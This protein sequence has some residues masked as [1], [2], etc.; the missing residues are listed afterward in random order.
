VLAWV[1]QLGVFA[2]VAAILYWLIG[3]YRTRTAEVGIPTGF[4][5]LDQPAN[6]TI[7]G[8]PFSQVQPVRDAFVQGMLNTLR[9]VVVGLVLTTVLGVA[10]GV[11]RLSHN[12]LVRQLATIYV[13]VLRNLPIALI[14]T[15]CF[16]GLVLQVLPRI[17][18]AWEPLGMLVL[19]NRGIGVP[20]FDGGSG[21]VLLGLLAVGAIGWWAIAR[22][23]R[24]RSDRTGAPARSGLWGG[25][26]LV[27][28]VAGGWLVLGYSVDLPEVDGRQVGGGM[29]VDPSYFAVLVALVV[30]TAS[31]I[32]EIVRGSILAVPP[33]QG[34]AADALALSGFQRLWYVVLPQAMRIA[35]PPLGNQYLNLIKNSSLAAGFAYVEITNVAQI[36]TAN[37]SPAIPAFT[38]ALVF[39]IV[40]SLTTSLIVNMAN[41]RFTLVG[42]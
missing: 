40:L 1:F 8:N 22:W 23:R 6:F 16:L 27:L 19:S 5:F 36:T 17:Q 30:Y 10:V 4:D 35:I 26:F 24:A 20:W 38:L 33:G 41:R 29:R 12:W 18:E 21:L 11:G 28:V 42:R 3:N 14:V 2:V 7:P 31:H 32:A 13:E 34:E 25:S 39:Y 15:F 9:M 37:G